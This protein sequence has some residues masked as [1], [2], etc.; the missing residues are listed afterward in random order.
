M[1]NKTGRNE[2]CSCG[3]GKKFKKC[4]GLQVQIQKQ[5][6]FEVLKKGAI[7]SSMGVS[8]RGLSDHIFKVMKNANEG[9]GHKSFKVTNKEGHSASSCCSHETHEGCHEESHSHE[10]CDES[11][12]K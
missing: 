7:N 1:S 6:K 2:L 4:C 3:S 10:P 9:I 8:T 11:V 12:K 5:M